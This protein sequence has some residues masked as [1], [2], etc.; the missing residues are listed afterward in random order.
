[1]GSCAFANAEG[2]ESGVMNDSGESP[3]VVLK[4]GGTSVSSAANWR[5]VAA[6]V[7]ARLDEGARPFVVHSALSGVTD[8]LEALL[9]AALEGD[10][11]DGLAEIERVHVRL[12]RELGIALPEAVSRILGDLRATTA[13]LDRVREVT[14]RVRAR[15]MSSGELMAT[16]L[17]AVYLRSQGLEI[18]WL[19]ARTALRADTRSG[20]HEKASLLSATCDFS[21]DAI[22][23]G[24]LQT[25]AAVIITQG[26]IA[27]D[28]AGET[29]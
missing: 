4:F 5:N 17:G 26:F 18:E 3:W 19:A 13:G 27:S 20:G 25:V 2:S 11:P 6:I 29:V 15:V 28:G 10:A 9:A 24:R 16:H 1:M 12:A 14:D 22:L 8:R 21:P 7:R 23:R